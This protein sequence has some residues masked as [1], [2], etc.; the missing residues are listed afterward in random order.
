MSVPNPD[1][2]YCVPIQTYF[3]DKTT[4]A[5]LSAGVVTFYEAGTGFTVPKKIYQQSNTPPYTFTVLSNPI[6][7]SGV[8]TFQDGS[9]N[10]INVYLYPYTGIPEDATRGAEQLYDITVYSSGGT[11]QETRFAWPPNVQASFGSA[12]TI[13]SANQITN[14][15]FVEVLFETPTTFT[16]NGP[17]VRTEIAPGWFVL[18]SSTG[19]ATFTV[20][21]TAVASGVS[22]N[23]TGAPYELTIAS[24]SLD[25]LAVYQR[26]QGSP[27]LLAGEPVYGYAQIASISG[28][29]AVSLTYED[30]SGNVVAL[31]GPLQTNVDN[32]FTTIEGAAT[33]P[34]A[35]TGTAP[36][37][38]VDFVIT[39]V[40][41]I[42]FK[43][44][45]VEMLSVANVSSKPGYFQQSV[46][47]QTN[48]LYWYDKP[49]LE[50][51]PIPSYLVGWD[52]ALN[53]CQAL[54]TSVSPVTQ[55]IT[56]NSYYIADQTILFQSVDAS[57]S[58]AQGQY[59]FT[60][61]AANTSSLAIIQYIPQ[62]IALEL[63]TGRMSIALGAGTTQTALNGT[64]NL[65]WTATNL[66]PI[67]TPTFASLVSSIASGPITTIAGGWTVVPR[68]LGS[69]TFTLSSSAITPFTFDGFDATAVNTSTAEFMAIVISFDQLTATKALKI[70]YCSLNAGDIATR[71]AP[72]T[73]D[74]VLRECQYYYQK[75]FLY[76]VVPAQNVGTNTGESYGLLGPGPIGPIVRYS[77]PLRTAL[78]PAVSIVTFYNPVA[79]TA[80]VHNFT[81]ASNWTATSTYTDTNSANGFVVGGTQL[82]GT[83]AA[84]LGVHWTADARLGVV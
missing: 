23:E 66:P 3:V 17:N 59:G 30:S 20:S 24:A 54:G 37:A 49:Q 44:T 9:G 60:I 83:T 8:G 71:P 64:V 38:Y 7:L 28:A 48:G 13:N 25:S 32:T 61:T 51:K 41:N 76:D 79:A 57:F 52:F 27:L 56:N 21:Q 19:S 81:D 10:D 46:P 36:T 53:P 40:P 35:A 70:Q 18:T 34:I 4:G 65:Y 31:T 63:L 75:S 72:Q 6:T 33:V 45:S 16:V 1:L 50:Y 84:L 68:A 69:A 11:L 39:L 15:Q 62:A 26:I 78:A 58:M 55:G 73:I 82:G 22:T 77:T 67:L 29:Q 5:P 12:S 14:S 43:I 74:Q 80:Y 42:T 2:I 47:Q